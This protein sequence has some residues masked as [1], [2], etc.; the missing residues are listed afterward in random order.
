MNQPGTVTEACVG[1]APTLITTLAILTHGPAREDLVRLHQ[2]LD[3][4]GDDLLRAAEAAG[5]DLPGPL[6]DTL[7]EALGVVG[8]ALSPDPVPA[9][10]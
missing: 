3:A 10:H 8:D 6:I 9:S 2:D 4:F 5:T 7:A 1:F